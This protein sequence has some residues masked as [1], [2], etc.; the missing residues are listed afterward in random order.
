MARPSFADHFSATADAYARHRPTY[1]GELFEWLASLA[2]ERETAWDCATGS[3]QAAV[4]LAHHFPRVIATDPSASQLAHARAHPKV[5]YFRSTA[6]NCGLPDAVVDLLT[7]ATAIHWFDIERFYAEVRRVT[8]PGAIIAVWSYGERIL[9]DSSID[10]L[11]GDFMHQQLQPYWPPQ[12]RYVKDGYRE[13]PFPFARIEPPQSFACKTNWNLD[14]L[15]AHMRTW[16]AVTAYR[17]KH[18]ADPTD[19]FAQQAAP[20]WTALAGGPHERCRVKWP[21]GLLVGRVWPGATQRA[22]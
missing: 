21:L 5:A 11:L 9:I 16:S 10:S 13:L 19:L 20:L 4:M 8:R 14:E 1:P 2:P 6:E 17:A 22:S 7:V 12:V 15:V 3:G 18:N